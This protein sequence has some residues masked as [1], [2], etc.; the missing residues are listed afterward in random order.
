MHLFGTS[1]L[2]T[3][4][5]T[6]ALTPGARTGACSSRRSATP[7]RRSKGGSITCRTRSENEP[8]EHSRCHRLGI[9]S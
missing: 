1:E 3:Q 9:S 4:P 7:S 8:T 6:P 5:G 2:D